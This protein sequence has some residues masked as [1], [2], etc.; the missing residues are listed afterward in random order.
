MTKQLLDDVKK[1]IS[2][3]VAKLA[4]AEVGFYADAFKADCPT[5]NS[6]DRE[7]KMFM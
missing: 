4:C 5:Q 3:Q 6:G 7:A 2:G 1:K